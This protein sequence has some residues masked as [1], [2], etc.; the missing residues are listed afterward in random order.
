MRNGYRL[1]ASAVVRRWRRRRRWRPQREAEETQE[2]GTRRTQQGNATDWQKSL[3]DPEPAAAAA[4]A[5]LPAAYKDRRP[6]LG[7]FRVCW[8]E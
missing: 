4:A 1:A 3:I 7:L 2:N 6:P 8:I 5:A